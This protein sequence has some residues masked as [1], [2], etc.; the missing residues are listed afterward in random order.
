MDQ[1][2]LLG[3]LG[4]SSGPWIDTPLD[5]KCRIYQLHGPPG[6]GKTTALATRWIPRAVE[7]YGTD[8]VA[9]CSLTRSAA[10]EIASR[11]L[12]VDPENVGT[13]HALAFRALGRPPMTV[14]RIADWNSRA[15]ADHQLSLGAAP[16]DS[17][18]SSD[19]APSKLEGDALQSSVELLRHCLRPFDSWPAAE[20]DWYILFRSWKLENNLLDFCDLIASAC[21]FT[22]GPKNAPHALIVDEAQD[23]SSLEHRLVAHWADSCEMLV[24]AGDGDQSIYS[25]RGA[26]ARAFSQNKNVRPEDQREL[27][28]SYRVPRSVV[29]Y[30]QDW[31][32]QHTAPRRAVTYLP[33]VDKAGSPVPGELSFEPSLTLRGGA[34]QLVAEISERTDTGNAMLLAS[35][36]YLLNTTI[37]V[38]RRSGIPFFNP[39]RPDFAPWNPLRGGASRLLSFLSPALPDRPSSPSNAPDQKDEYPDTEASNASTGPLTAPS[40]S[41]H[42]LA[43]WVGPLHADP[44][45]LKRGA[46]TLVT[47]RG[48]E[49]RD[50]LLLSDI[51]LRMVFTDEGLAAAREHLVSGD[52]QAAVR[53]YLPLVRSS[54][55]RTFAYAEAVIEN[56]DFGIGG[57]L[58]E[59]PLVVGT[60]HSVKGAAA[61]TVFLA[62][63]LSMAGYRQWLDDGSPEQDEMVRLF[64][65]GMTRCRDTLVLLGPSS[66]ARVSWPDQESS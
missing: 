49:D 48:K 46:K 53:W 42:D 19:S 63:D 29:N 13:L 27:T 16:P 41:W 28:Q 34:H 39:F 11:G 17:E 18:V 43:R 15:D 10:H 2:H 33:R 56:P 30:A 37:A 23:L 8:G 57:L 54:M 21:E 51:E 52:F 5:P 66:M 6:C 62:P 47:E 35:C 44:L 3:H 31:I 50:R 60:I 12:Q 22:I 45:I 32:A 58:D 40:W 26:D 65:V 4:D 25:W 1:H 36:G 61:D 24:L 7:L 14:S 59:P 64:Y 55:R 20:R 9:V 38:L